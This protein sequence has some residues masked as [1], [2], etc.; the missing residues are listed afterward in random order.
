MNSFRHHRLHLGTGVGVVVAIAALSLAPSSQAA[1][2]PVDDR[3][4]P[5]RCNWTTD[6]LPRSADAVEG[7]YRGCGRV[8]LPRSADGVEGWTR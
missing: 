4:V 1:P 5:T 3:P 8:G 2:A 6:E 7:W